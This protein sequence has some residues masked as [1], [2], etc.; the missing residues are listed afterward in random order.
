MIKASEERIEQSK[1]KT[2]IREI[3][4]VIRAEFIIKICKY[5]LST[6]KWLE[7]EYPDELW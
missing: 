2:D 7:D 3:T 4:K 1:D 6:N 5:L